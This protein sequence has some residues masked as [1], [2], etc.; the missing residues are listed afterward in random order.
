MEKCYEY[1]DCDS[2]DCSKRKNNGKHCWKMEDDLCHVH[3][4]DVIFLRKE[5]ENKKEACKFCFYYKLQTENLIQ[6]ER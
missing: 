3:S 5:F 6:G 2:K 4:Q 1:F